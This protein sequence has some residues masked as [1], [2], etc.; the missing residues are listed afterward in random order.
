M[1]TTTELEQQLRFMLLSQYGLEKIVT[2]VD[3]TEDDLSIIVKYTE[4]TKIKSLATSRLQKMNS[5]HI[6]HLLEQYGRAK[7]TEGFA[8]ARFRP[9]FEN[10]LKQRYR[11]ATQPEQLAIRK[12]LSE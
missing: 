4:S 9:K 8:A 2:R 7:N 6:V 10:E 11:Y 5:K 12:T 3:A 1:D